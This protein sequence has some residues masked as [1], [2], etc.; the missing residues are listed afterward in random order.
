M[1]YTDNKVPRY[2]DMTPD[3]AI[4]HIKGIENHVCETLRDALIVAEKA[5]QRVTPTRTTHQATI[6]KCNTCPNCLNVVDETV[7]FIPGQIFHGKPSYCK[8]CG[9]A[10]LWE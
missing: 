10:L 4:L 5:L 8:F 2:G 6:R 1:S 3:I 7:E 9:Q